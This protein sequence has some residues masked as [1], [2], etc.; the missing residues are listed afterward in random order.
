[1]FRKYIVS[2]AGAIDQSLQMPAGFW[3]LCMVTLKLSAAATT[4]SQNFE[5][6][7]DSGDGVDYDVPLHT[8]EM[9]AAGGVTDVYTPVEY[10]LLDGGEPTGPAG[11]KLKIT[12][13]NTDSRTVGIVA[14]VQRKR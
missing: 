9:V 3:R 14:W 6:S 4:G 8:V 13:P 5:I 7:I 1:M 12:F 2:G 11:D 10:L